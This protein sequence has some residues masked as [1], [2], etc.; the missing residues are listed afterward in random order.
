MNKRINTE[1]IINASAERVWKVL[2]DFSSYPR[3]NPF[4]TSI[5]GQLR[6]GNRLTNT[7]KNGDKQFVFKPRVLE[8]TEQVSFSWLGSLFMKGLFDGTHYFRLE[9]T[10]A[11]QVKLTHGEIFSG[12]L[13]SSILKKI[14]SDTR[15][16]FVR[17][18]RALKQ[19][20]ER[21]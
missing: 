3:W 2:T 12:I 20:A 17:M 5:E 7:L 19:E 4:I 21:I 15:D 9:K 16:N 10:G 6:Q 11:N 8:V 1:I 14:G 13:S 18:N